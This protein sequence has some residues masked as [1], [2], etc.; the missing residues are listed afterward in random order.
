MFRLG[1]AGNYALQARLTYNSALY[2]SSLAML[3]SCFLKNYLKIKKTLYVLNVWS[4]KC[5][6]KSNRS[7]SKKSFP[8]LRV[9]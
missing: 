1:R 4:A 7:F 8:A 5:T 3:V 6:Q 2:N 9:K